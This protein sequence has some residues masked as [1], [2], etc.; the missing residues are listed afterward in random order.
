MPLLAPSVPPG[1]QPYST[2]VAPE[3]FEQMR[4]YMSCVDPEE[5]SLREAKM[6]KTLDELSRD[7]LAQRSYAI[8]FRTEQATERSVR[9][10]ATTQKMADEVVG[11][12]G[13]E[14]KNAMA[15]ERGGFVMGSHTDMSGERDNRSRNSRQTKSSWVRRNQNK[16]RATG[17][18]RERSSKDNEEGGAWITR[19]HRGEVGMHARDALLPSPDRL[20]A[21]MN[22]LLWVLRSLRDLRFRRVIAFEVES[23]GSNKVAIEIANSVLRDGRLQSYLALGG[24]SWLHDLIQT[25]VTFV[26]S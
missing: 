13:M 11:R 18:V 24:P 16:R 3:V 15:L 23:R 25:E 1:F 21:E 4:I 22:C 8:G 6:K 2:V 20:S 19:D 5:R 17:V 7:P 10:K 9:L 12:H 14:E 26:N